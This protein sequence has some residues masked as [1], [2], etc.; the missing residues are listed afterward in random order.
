ICRLGWSCK[1]SPATEENPIT[2][3]RMALIEAIQKADDGNF[4]R[5]LAET[6]L[7]I[8]M[9]ADVE[10]LIGAGRHERSDGRLTYRNGYR[11]RTLD[12][13]LGSL[14]LRIPK[15][16]QGSYF[17]GFLEPR[18]PVEKAL[19]SVIQEAWIGGVSTRRVDDLVQAMGMTGI[20]KSSVSKLC[21][22]ID[23][24]VNSFL[25]RPLEGEW[26]YLW[27]DA[28]YLKV[29]AAGR[30]V[31]VAAII[32]VAVNTDGRRE[33]VG[34]HLGPSEAEVFW[35]DFLRSLKGRDLTGIKLVISDAHEGLK[36]AIIR[37]LGATWQRCRVGLLKN[38][39]GRDSLLNIVWLGLARQRDAGEQGARSAGV[40]RQWFA[41]SVDPRRPPF[42]PGRPG[43]RSVLAA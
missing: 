24:R 41:A 40:V 22:D 37:V 7:Q 34:L 6:V 10:A 17:P 15:L 25:N 1:P 14:T 20:S 42:D 9:D 33:I 29:R 28:T 18:R 12:T 3:D 26:P 31:S 5:A 23:E 21:K 43:A 8:I 32:A 30:I 2:E 4:L 39:H 36:A 11:D 27:L 16:R 13:R 38:P 19:V 35:S